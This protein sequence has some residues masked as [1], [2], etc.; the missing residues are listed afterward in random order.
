MNEE[1]SGQAEQASDAFRLFVFFVGSLSLP[2]FSVAWGFSI[3]TALPLLIFVLVVYGT[4][5][6]AAT[7]N[8]FHATLAAHVLSIILL[9]LGIG[10]IILASFVIWSVI[11]YYPG[12]I[13][14]WMTVNIGIFDVQLVTRPW[15]LMVVTVLLVIIAVGTFFSRRFF[16]FFWV[17]PLERKLRYR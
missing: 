17:G 16:S 1:T 13:T 8:P 12:N 15:S 4:A 10:M 7:K 3:I 14:S 9:L 2:S 6:A 5:M 11:M